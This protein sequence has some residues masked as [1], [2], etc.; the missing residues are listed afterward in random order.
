MTSIDRA[1]RLIEL[2]GT[3]TGNP[4][5]VALE[6]AIAGLLAPNLPPVTRPKPGSPEWDAYMADWYAEPMWETPE[7]RGFSAGHEEGS[8]NIYVFRDGYT[9]TDIDILTPEEAEALGLALLAA[10]Q[11]ARGRHD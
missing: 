3:R 10:A 9:I 11:H 2:Y 5:D 4:R 1:V 8:V 6:L 7:R